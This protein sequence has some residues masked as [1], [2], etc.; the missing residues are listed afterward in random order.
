MKVMANLGVKISTAKSH[1]SP[2]LYEFAKRLVY[3]DTEISPFPYSALKLAGRSNTALATLLMSEQEKGWS[4]PH[5]ISS[6]VADFLGIVKSLPSRVKS[7]G[8]DDA[9]M[10]EQIISI[11]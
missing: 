5:G 9:F 11:I 8:R 2:H 6:A 10:T 3:K 1:T 7:K 4:F